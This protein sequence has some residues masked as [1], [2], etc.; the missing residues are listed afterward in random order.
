MTAA[1]ISSEKVEGTDVYGPDR[2]KI[3]SIDHLMIDKSSGHVGYAIMKFGGFLGL[4]QS[5]Y[6]LPWGKLSYDN[7]LDG[8]IADVTE[9]QVKNAPD[10][11]EDSFKNRDW[12]TKTHDHYQTRYYWEH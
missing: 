7:N 12:E 4:G 8:Y 2:D 11:D 9:E 5:A 6:P 1:L 3:G 10:Y